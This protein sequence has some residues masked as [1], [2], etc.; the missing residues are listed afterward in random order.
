ME[1]RWNTP[2]LPDSPK[3]FQNIAPIL[4]V[5]PPFSGKNPSVLL[6]DLGFSNKQHDLRQETS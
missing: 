1:L 3:I 4:P 2:F 5:Q 6:G